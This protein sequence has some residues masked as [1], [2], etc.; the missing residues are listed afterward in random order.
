[1]SVTSTSPLGELE[2]AGPTGA[3][4]EQTGQ[5][6]REPDEARGPFVR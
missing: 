5:R 1:M 4:L 6:V 2:A 3:E